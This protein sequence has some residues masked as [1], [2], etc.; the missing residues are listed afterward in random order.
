MFKWSAWSFNFTEYVDNETENYYP[1]GLHSAA[2]FY[3]VPS[4]S[5]AAASTATFSAF[6]G[7][8]SVVKVQIRST[9]IFLNSENIGW[10]GTF[11]SK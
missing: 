11:Y 3:L 2:N 1:T 5:N 8:R 10:N 6:N 4:N 9:L 7:T